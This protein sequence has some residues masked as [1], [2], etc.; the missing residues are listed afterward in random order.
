M[1]KL[2]KGLARASRAPAAARHEARPDG[3]AA[4]HQHRPAA[5][6]VVE[7]AAAVGGG[8][9]K[10]EALRGLGDLGLAG[11]EQRGGGGDGREGGRPLEAPHAEGLFV[12]GWLWGM[13]EW[14]IG[15]GAASIQ[16]G[17]GR[18]GGSAWTDG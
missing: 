8:G 9:G 5:H 1:E 13:F 15:R 4:T 12:L 16:I 3:R 14:L 7:V 2:G 18:V 11:A 6:A 17:M 10:D